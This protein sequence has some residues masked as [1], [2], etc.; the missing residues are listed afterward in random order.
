VGKDEPLKILLDNPE[1]IA[2]AVCI[3]AAAG[4][5]A[6]IRGYLRG[7]PALRWLLSCVVLGPFALL[8]GIVLTHGISRTG[9]PLP[10]DSRRLEELRSLDPFSGKPLF[11]DDVRRLKREGR[12]NEAVELLN[13]L[14]DAIEDKARSTGRSV[15]AWYYE[16]LSA[17]Y[18]RQ[19]KR[20]S[21]RK[22]LERYVACHHS[23]DLRTRKMIARLE[24]IKAA[25]QNSGR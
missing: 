21:E 17:L 18:R 14:I 3:W 12:L 6:F 20:E 1:L 19:G 8:L 5:L 10:A 11:S 23:P 9:A 7:L 25:A 4:A 15:P 24:R 22:I 2:A 16:Q 13:S